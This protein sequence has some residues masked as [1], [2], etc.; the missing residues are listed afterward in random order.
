[1]TTYSYKLVDM[2]NLQLPYYGW[3]TIGLCKM[4]SK[5][6][7]SH[8]YRCCSCTFLLPKPLAGPRNPLDNNRTGHASDCPPSFCSGARSAL[9]CSK[10]RSHLWSTLNDI[11][12][13]PRLIGTEQEIGK[14]IHYL[15]RIDR[16]IG[17]CNL[18][19]SQ[20]S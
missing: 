20:A 19:A 18:S 8:S 11:F 4:Y 7:G 6:F 10:I 1:M 2:Y 16:Q 3:S 13:T 14:D 15:T 9:L 5:L 12:P 17:H